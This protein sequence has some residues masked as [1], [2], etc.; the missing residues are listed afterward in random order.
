MKNQ[1]V[2]VIAQN[3]DLLKKFEEKDDAIA[4]AKVE[5]AEAKRLQQVYKQNIESLKLAGWFQQMVVGGTVSLFMAGATAFFSNS[6]NLMYKGIK[7]A[8]IWVYT[9]VTT[10]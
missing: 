4:N 5:A 7:A 3:R 2:Q 10:R 9:W 6:L 8:S 1:Q